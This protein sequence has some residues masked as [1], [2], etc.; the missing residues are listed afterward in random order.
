MYTR[1]EL[2]V[3]LPLLCIMVGITIA[4]YMLLK[5]KSKRIQNIPFI[6]ITIL[7]WIGE[8][9]KQILNFRDGF[10]AWRLPIHYCSTLFIWFTL[11]EFTKGKFRNVMENIA[12]VSA[13]LLFAVFYLYPR[14]IL[15]DN[16]EQPFEDYYSFH[17]IYHHH[18]SLL[19]FMLG[20]AFKRFH[21]THKLGWIWVLCTSIYY[22]IAII[23]AYALDTNF[24]NILESVIPPVESLRLLCGQVVYTIGLGG[25]LIFFG[26]SVFWI[27]TWFVN[28][29]KK[30]D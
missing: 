23:C 28:R 8:I 14:G 16:C 11:A 1:A 5:N 12:F 24:F 17:S 13:L 27:S 10:D 19:Y 20:V 29:K 30:Q 7:L 9:I 21:P 2:I 18:M 26:A 15:G 6:A 3:L 25:V 4:L 22:I